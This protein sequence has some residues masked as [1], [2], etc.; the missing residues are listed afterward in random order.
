MDKRIIHSVFEETATRFPN[1]IAIREDQEQISYQALNES[2][3][4]LAHLLCYLGIKTS[5]IVGVMIPGSINLVTA[6]LASFKSGGIYLPVDMKF[7]HKRITEI[8][9]QSRPDVLVVND[10]DLEE[11]QAILD[12]LKPGGKLFIVTLD[13]MH[14]T[15]IHLYR[16]QRME[17]IAK[18]LPEYYTGNPAVRV[19]PD[20]EN[21]IFYTS[22]STGMAKAFAGCHKSLSHFIHWELKEFGLDEHCRVSQL[23]QFTFDA[24]LRDILLPLSCGG[25][26]CIPRAETKNNTVRLIE[27]IDESAI[28]LIH[29]VPSLF[30]LLSNEIAVNQMPLPVFPHLRYLLMAGEPLFVK[31]IRDWWE[32]VGQHVEI[33]NLYGTSET[34]LAKTFHR[35]TAIE[36]DPAQAIHAGKPIDN[37]DILVM[38]DL[39]LCGTGETGEVFIRT[40]FMTK[41]YYNNPKLNEEAFINNPLKEGEKAAPYG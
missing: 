18:G 36:E 40:P 21:Y 1:R 35:I 32:R 39:V 5:K 3:N 26:L 27:W 9:Q 38:N 25:C 7:S 20:D 8:F 19:A 11:L 16:E 23:S 6:L 30:R 33:V 41:G 2:A 13:A 4:R 31:D 10:A 34:T 29:C 24:A 37:A 22:G 15:H 28:T 14:G 12:E 17:K